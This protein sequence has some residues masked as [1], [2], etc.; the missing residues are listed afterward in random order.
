MLTTATITIGEATIVVT[1]DD[2]AVSTPNTSVLPT[3]AAVPAPPKA[4]KA[5]K[6]T[7]T[8]TQPKA[9]RP[10]AAKVDN[11]ALLAQIRSEAAA[12]NYATAA[13]LAS[14][15]G[16]AQEAARWAEKDAMTSKASP[17]QEAKPAQ[18]PKATQDKP[19]ASKPRS[20]PKATQRSTK[21]ATTK[22]KAKTVPAG[23]VAAPAERVT[24][25]ATAAKLDAKQAKAAAKQDQRKDAAV[26]IDVWRSQVASAIKA[27]DVDMQ[28]DLFCTIT[29]AIERLDILADKAEP[30]AARIMQDDAAELTDLVEQLHR[31]ERKRATVKA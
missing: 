29:E 8:K 24:D 13:K 26:E 14:D 19:K 30:H 31:A 3:P 1:A 7:T 5:P 17:V 10:K 11:K 27:K 12:G 2:Q 9:A 18:E 15:R 21:S 4:T 20:T 25:E 16:W 22:S 6:A 23:T 28:A